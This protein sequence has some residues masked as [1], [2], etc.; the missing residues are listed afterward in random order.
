MKRFLILK[1]KNLVTKSA[2]WFMPFIICNFLILISSSVFSQ[3]NKSEKTWVIT[4]LLNPQK[5]VT[6]LGHP[7]IIDS[8]YGNAV[9]FNGVDDGIFLEKMPL[10]GL[11]KFTIEMIIRFDRGGHEE[12]R[13]FHTGTLKQDRVLMEMRSD[14]DTW[15]LDGMFESKGKWVVLMD[16]EQAH[17]LDKWYH[18]AFTVE[19]GKQVTF[20]NGK[21]E[22]EGSVE[23][24]PIID[25]STSI[26]VRQNRVSWF[27][28]AIYCIRF[29]D[30]VLR[31]CEF[32]N[33]E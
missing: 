18:I 2:A 3:D 26:G 25:G 19:D 16:Q 22:L 9:Q 20:V 8:P 7:K 24:S 30:K 4:D 15:Y 23:F 32:M 11:S 5:D 12:Q 10:K 6:V 17:P 14:D 1:N 29:S 21:K 28:G 13:Y 27:K 33:F 31:P